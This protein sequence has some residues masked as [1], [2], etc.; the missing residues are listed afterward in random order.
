MNTYKNGDCIL[1]SMK[2]KFTVGGIVQMGIRFFQNLIYV[3]TFQFHKVSIYHHVACIVANNGRLHVYEAID[4][5]YV[6]S[7]DVYKFLADNK[8]HKYLVRRPIGLNESLYLQRQEEMLGKK[9]WFW[10]TLFLQ[11]IKQ[12]TLDYV[13]LGSHKK[14]FDKVYCSEAYGY[15]MDYKRWWTVDPQDIYVDKNLVSL[16]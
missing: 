10:G 8:I 1:I 5:G 11:I 15:A 14:K 12:L 2:F 6:D 13:W 9:Y 3:I 7:G 16:S 4:K